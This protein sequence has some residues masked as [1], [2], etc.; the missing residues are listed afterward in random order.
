M[1]YLDMFDEDLI[2]NDDPI[3]TWI[4]E[5]NASIVKEIPLATVKKQLKEDFKEE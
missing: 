5:N 3:D 1:N 4:K 2:E